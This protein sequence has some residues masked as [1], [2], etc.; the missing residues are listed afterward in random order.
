[1]ST[2]IDDGVEY[3]VACNGAHNG[4]N[5]DLF[6]R[7]DYVEP[8]VPVAKVARKVYAV[9]QCAQCGKDKPITN[10]SF[11]TLTKF[12][13]RSCSQLHWRTQQREAVRSSQVAA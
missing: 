10:R 5:E 1:M 9:I 11:L 3:E 12:C 13:G 7:I 4:N 8:P 2:V 6:R